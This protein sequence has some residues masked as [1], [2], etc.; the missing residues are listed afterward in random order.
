MIKTKVSTRAPMRIGVVV[1]NCLSESIVVNI[2]STPF[3][4]VIDLDHLGLLARCALRGSFDRGSTT[5]HF[6][7]KRWKG[8]TRWR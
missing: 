3:Q 7:S 6:G 5:A 4:L 2:C 1:L 8:M